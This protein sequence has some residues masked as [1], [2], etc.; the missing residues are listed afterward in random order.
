MNKL[1]WLLIAVVPQLSWAQSDGKGFTT[2]PVTRLETNRGVTPARATGTREVTLQQLHDRLGLSDPQQGLWSVFESRVDSYTSAYYRQKPIDPSP[3][4]AAPHQIGRMVD[5]LQNRLA[6]LEEVEDAAK[7]LYANLTS[8]Q[9]K[10][11][12]QML[13]LVIPSF[14]N[15]G[16]GSTNTSPEARRKDGKLDG[17]KKSH[18]SATGSGLGSQ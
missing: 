18:R 6:A 11:A 1:A 4:D 3:D 12:N 16:D 5:N 8:E 15:S 2:D 7:T 9:Q 17:S 14:T 10:T 13:I